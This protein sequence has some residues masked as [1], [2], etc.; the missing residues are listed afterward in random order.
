MNPPG[1][2]FLARAALGQQQHRNFT[3]R[4]L[5]HHRFHAPH[6]RTNALDKVRRVQDRRNIVQRLAKHYFH[7]AI[8]IFSG[9]IPKKPT[10]PEPFLK[11]GLCHFLRRAVSLALQP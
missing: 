5:A 7:H 4:Y 10:L 8:L 11:H 1:H 6:A 9:K 3:V 2:R